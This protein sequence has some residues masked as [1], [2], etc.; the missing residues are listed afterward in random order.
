MVL[1][2]LV[3]SYFPLRAPMGTIDSTCG[4]AS[5]DLMRGIVVGLWEEKE[6]NFNCLWQ[7]GGGKAEKCFQTLQQVFKNFPNILHL[8]KRSAKPPEQTWGVCKGYLNSLLCHYSQLLVTKTKQRLWSWCN[9]S[10][11]IPSK[12]AQEFR[13][14]AINL[15]SSCSR[16]PPYEYSHDICFYTSIKLMFHPYLFKLWV[17][18][19]YCNL[20]DW[21]SN[22]I[23]APP[24][25]AQHW[26]LKRE[27]THGSL[28]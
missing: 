5:L 18:A 1:R 2:C 20:C 10:S 6:S 24:A 19:S 28:W 23:A 8:F 25:G 7:D 12:I 11:R 22:V 15:H 16:R 9:L 26:K 14:K 4:R 27:T 17:W 3:A 13:A 21:Q